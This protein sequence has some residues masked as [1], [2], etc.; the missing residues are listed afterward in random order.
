MSDFAEPTFFMIAFGSGSSMKLFHRWRSEELKSGWHGV[1]I[2]FL[3]FPFPSLVVAI[4]LFLIQS[5]RRW[6]WSDCK[7][8]HFNGGSSGSY[9][10]RMVYIGIIRCSSFMTWSSLHL[11]KPNAWVRQCEWRT[12]TVCIFR[13]KLFLQPALWSPSGSISL[14]YLWSNLFNRAE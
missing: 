10:K 14:L 5:A 11:N 6:T 7:N 8:T 4:W 3:K 12:K 13:M 2:I 9:C 1:Q